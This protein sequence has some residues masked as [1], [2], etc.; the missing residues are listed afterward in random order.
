VN[1]EASEANPRAVRILGELKAA[2]ITHIVWVPDSESHFMHQALASDPEFTIIQVCR[3]G[4][5]VA[6]CTGLYLG[7]VR[8]ALLVENQGMFEFGNVL[9][10]ARAL[11]VPMVMLV[12]YLFFHKMEK[13]DGSMVWNNKRDYTEPF[14]DAFEID[15]WLVDSDNDVAFVREA[16]RRAYESNRPVAALLTKADN[17]EAGN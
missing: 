17:F 10:W 1:S 16:C 7:G 14:L 9:K 15:Y 6:I 11:E 2:G 4:E 12:A 3:E 5:C 8:A 13:I